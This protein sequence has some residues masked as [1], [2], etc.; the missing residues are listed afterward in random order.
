VF[1]S[2]LGGRRINKKNISV[3]T[4]EY[5]GTNSLDPAGLIRAAAAYNF[6]FGACTRPGT[7]NTFRRIGV[8][9]SIS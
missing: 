5:D 6:F 2:S 9:S 4:R 8:E 3:Y 1:T 7:V